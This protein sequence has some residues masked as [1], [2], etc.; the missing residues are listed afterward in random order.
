MLQAQF[1]QNR[2]DDYYEHDETFALLIIFSPLH[3]S[4]YVT[5]S[6]WFFSKGARREA[7][8]FGEL[9]F[10]LIE[11]DNRVLL[12]LLEANTRSS[13]SC[14]ESIAM[15]LKLSAAN[16]RQRAHSTRALTLT[17]TPPLSLC[18]DWL[19]RERTSY[20]LNSA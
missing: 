20:P 13:A 18:L 8:S 1:A 12:A 19:S 3:C 14:S 9:S 5:E 11:V 7:N 16:F 15:R 6:L 17:L 2:R 10:S 4:G